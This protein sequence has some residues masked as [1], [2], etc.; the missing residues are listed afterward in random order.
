M[1]KENSQGKTQIANISQLRQSTKATTGGIPC[2]VQYNGTDIGKR[3]V[4][5]RSKVSLGRALTNDIAISEASVSRI[6]AQILGEGRHVYIEDLGSSNGTYIN[7]KA[8]LEKSQLKDQDIVRLGTVLFKFFSADNVEGFIQDKMYKLATIDA[9]TQTFNKQYLLD[10]LASEFK[11]S[12][13]TGRPL[14]VIYL[15]L[16]HFKQV[17]DKYGHNAGDQV[18][19]DTAKLV[20]NLIRKDD[21]F[22]RFGGEEFVVVLPKTTALQAA[23]TAETMRERA[24]QWP[25]TLLISSGERID[26]HQ[27]ISIGVAELDDTMNSY[28][29]LLELAD[30]KLYR[31]K[32]GGRNRVTV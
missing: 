11:K 9:G 1:T 4:I 7:D 8:I 2:L 15:D 5:D 27:T 19:R 26:H 24:S 6:H 3:H 28:K 17:N 18:L 22:A 14:A 10:T 32:E 31:S 23:K 30:R 12:K 29:D 16:D 20:K 21:V 25:H 13:S